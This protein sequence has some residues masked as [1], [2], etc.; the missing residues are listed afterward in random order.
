MKK[1]DDDF[2]IKTKFLADILG[3]LRQ[4]NLLFQKNNITIHEVQT[5][6]NIMTQTIN[7]AFIGNN[8]AEPTWG[9]HLLYE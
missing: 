4:M 3:M 7:M 2:I 6:L 8:E 9:I 5:Q 1:I